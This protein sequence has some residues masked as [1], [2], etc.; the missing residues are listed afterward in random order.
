M[1]LPSAKRVQG[2]TSIM[3]FH[4]LMFL[5]YTDD[6]DRNKMTY[7]TE[8]W[9]KTQPFFRNPLITSQST[10]PFQPWFP[11]YAF[12]YR[13]SVNLQG[14]YDDYNAP[15][16]LISDPGRTPFVAPFWNWKYLPADIAGNEIQ[17]FLVDGKLPILFVD[18]HVETMTPQEYMDRKLNEMPRKP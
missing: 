9:E 7:D 3:W 4:Q 12:N 11:G 8:W 5:I 2:N 13:I 10:H 6:A 14:W 16:C 18:G 1:K 15:L 17:A